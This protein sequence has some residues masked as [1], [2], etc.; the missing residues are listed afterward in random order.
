MMLVLFASLA[1]ALRLRP[2]F[3]WVIPCALLLAACSTDFVAPEDERC[4]L[5]TTPDEPAEI[6]RWM[7]EHCESVRVI[8]LVPAASASHSPRVTTP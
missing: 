2:T 6:T 1:W 4:T 8:V 7:I 5:Y 3:Y